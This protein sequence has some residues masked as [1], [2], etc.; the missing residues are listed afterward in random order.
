MMIFVTVESLIVQKNT[1]IV[2][3]EVKYVDLNVI[4]LIV[5]ILIKIKN[6]QIKAHKD[7]Y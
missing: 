7:N 6:N 1:V 2:I 3:E 4:V 5:I